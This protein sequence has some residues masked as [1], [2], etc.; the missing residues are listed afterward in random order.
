MRLLLVSSF[1]Q[2]V[3]GAERRIRVFLDELRNFKEVDHI[4][5]LSMDMNYED[6]FI[7]VHLCRSPSELI[8]IGKKLIKNVDV[9]QQHNYQGISPYIIDVANEAK[10]PSIFV[11]HDFRCICPALYLITD[12][13]ECDTLERRI[14]RDNCPV[15][16]GKGLFDLEIKYS[17]VLNRATVGVCAGEHARDTLYRN[18][19]LLGRIRLITGWIDP[20]FLDEPRKSELYPP[21]LVFMGNLHRYKGFHILVHALPQIIKNCGNVQLRFFSD[22]GPIDLIYGLAEKLG[23]LN[24]LYYAGMQDPFKLRQQYYEANLTLQPALWNEIIGLSIPESLA[25][26]TSVVASSMPSIMEHFGDYITT[27][28]PGD[29]ADFAEKISTLLNDKKLRAELATKG[30]EFV[31]KNYDVNRATRDFV[32]LYQELIKK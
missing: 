7:T 31:V 8:S 1:F 26:G 3:G 17:E 30:R 20:I 21:R 28:I 22:N 14:N 27:A 11:V 19:M 2:F 29:S 32:Q 18:D 23:V 25:C 9:V 10:K 16:V 13:F 6:D 4:D 5:M 24:N 15:C 12:K